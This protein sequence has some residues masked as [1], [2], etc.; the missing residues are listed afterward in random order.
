[1]KKMKIATIVAAVAV[2][3][4]VGAI[5]AFGQVSHKS[6]FG[7]HF[8]GLMGHDEQMIDHLSDKLKLSGQQ[9]TQ[10]KQILADSKPRFQPLFERLK[11]THKESM[12]LGSNGVFDERKSQEFAGKQAEIIKQILVEKEKTKA[13][14][15]AV[16]TPEQ[17]EQAKQMMNE[18]VEKFDH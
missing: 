4:I 1:M 11:E 10:A 14:I 2:V 16:L 8:A 6:G 5:I 12:E 15:F 18:F 9:K 7:N 13:A 17:R 3:S